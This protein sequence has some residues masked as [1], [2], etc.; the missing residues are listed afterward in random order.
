MLKKTSLSD[1]MLTST[2]NTKSTELENKI[3][4]TDIIAKSAITKANT[5]KSDLTDYAKKADVATDIAAIKNDYVTTASLT[6]E[7]N[8]LKSK[9]LATEV[10]AIDNKTK[11]NATDILALESILQQKEDTTNENERGNS[12]ARGLFFYIDQSYL[13]Y[14]CKLGSFDFNINKISKWKSTG[15]FNY[16]SNSKYFTSSGMIAVGDASGDLPD[17]KNDGRMYVYLSGNYFQQNKVIIAN[18]NN[19]I[20]I[21]FVYQIEPIS[22]SRDDIFTVQNALFGAMQIT[23]NADTSKYKYK[24]YGICFDEGGSFNKGNINNGRNV[25]IFGVHENSLVHENNKANNIYVM[26]DLFVQGINDTTLYA[27]K[28]YSQNFTQPSTKFVLSLHYNGD[29]SYLFVHG[30]QELKCKAKRES[31]VREKLCIGNISDKWSTSE[32]EKNRIIWK[33]L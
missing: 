23:K 14:N 20:N 3:K 17:L 30:K 25:L 31:L 13:V 1:Y 19:V 8:D 2:F 5:I 7:L 24:G 26:G 16:F 32:S 22:S 9:H 12:F 29:G 4:S 27:E 11:H 15:I 28:I 18:N 21:Y 33:Y 6:S 10:T